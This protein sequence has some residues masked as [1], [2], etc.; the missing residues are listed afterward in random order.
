MRLGDLLKG[1][2]WCLA[3]LGLEP[4][5]WVMPEPVGSTPVLCLLPEANDFWRR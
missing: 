2:S 3:G 5:V 4:G 1:H